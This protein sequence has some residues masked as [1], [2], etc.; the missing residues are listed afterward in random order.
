[1]H[2]SKQV[3]LTIRSQALT[4]YSEGKPLLEI[5]KATGYSKSAFFKHRNRALTK[6]LVKGG[7]ILP[8]HV[9]DSHGCGRAA[10]GNT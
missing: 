6:G 2:H 10:E 1:M 5:N 9:N 3:D 8:D 4:L 7:P